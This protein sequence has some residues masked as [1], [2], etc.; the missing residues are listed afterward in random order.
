MTKSTCVLCGQPAA[1]FYKIDKPICAI[2]H[3]KIIDYAA[4]LEARIDRMRQRADKELTE[5]RAT[6][7]RAHQMA[8]AIP[9]GQPILIGHHSEGRDRRYRDRIHSTYE[10]GFTR[11]PRQAAGHGLSPAPGAGE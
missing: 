6:L 3:N 2:C 8:Q 1:L 5:A 7:D 10:R 11:P 4:R 9:F